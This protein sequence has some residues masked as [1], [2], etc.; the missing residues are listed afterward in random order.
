MDR[1]KISNF[2]VKYILSDGLSTDS[3]TSGSQLGAKGWM[4]DTSKNV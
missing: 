2:R 1:S 3:F 4:C